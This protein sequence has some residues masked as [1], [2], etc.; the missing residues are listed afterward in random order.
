MEHEKEIRLF[1]GQWVNIVNH[2]NCFAD[3]A[4][5]DAVNKAVKMTEEAMAKNMLDG[6]WPSKRKDT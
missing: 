2:D 3:Y 5:E 6:V 1:D 4:V